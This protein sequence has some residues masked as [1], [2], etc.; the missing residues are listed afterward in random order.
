MLY[1][2]GDHEVVVLDFE[3]SG[4]SPDHGDRAIEIGAVLLRE[5]V[6]VDR[7][8]SLM[9]PGRRVNS[10]IE[11]YTGITNEMLSAAPQ[12]S[13]VMAEFADFIGDTPLVA[14]NASFD[15]RFLDAE[16]GH[17]GRRRKQD[18][19]CSLLVARRLY[20]EAPNH[21]LETLI[22]YKGLP[23]DGR[24]HRAM[25][26]SEMTASLWMRMVSDLQSICGLSRISFE[27]MRD[28]GGIA[29][30]KVSTYLEKLAVQGG[31]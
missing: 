23:V 10:F 22:R 29:R 2:G 12:A 17:I 6:I 26:D 28:L 15:R 5:G 25:A 16:L 31:G 1:P 19:G 3:T 9:N 7:Y 18:F 11:A 21:K 20:P 14:H 13:K 30:K 8:Q 27:L 24:F 4:M